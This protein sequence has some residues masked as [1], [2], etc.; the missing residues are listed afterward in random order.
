MTDHDYP[1]KV[2]FSEAKILI[3]EGDLLLFQ[4]NPLIAIAGRGRYSHAAKVA[5]WGS[6]LFCLEVR[7]FHGGRAIML[8]S[9]VERYPGKIDVFESN[10]NN[11]W[12]EYRCHASTRFMRRLTGC[13]YGWR[14]VFRAALSH[15]A[16]TRLFFRPSCQ[17]MDDQQV[18]TQLPGK[19]TPF[20]SQA[21]VMAERIGGTVDPVPQLA[22]R[23]TEPSDL[24]RSP[25]YR[26]R[27]TLGTE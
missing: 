23:W 18:F 20:C 22:D 8:Q 9:L 21:V 10:P 19:E 6:D 12:P 4:G 16:L 25:F 11:Q 5:R 3:A 15:M 26:Y 1:C 27:F 14:N 7:E 24:A 13:R 2:P 17:D